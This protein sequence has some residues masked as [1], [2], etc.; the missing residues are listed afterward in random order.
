MVSTG[1][2]TYPRLFFFGITDMI[3]V[4]S[5]VFLI[6]TTRVGLKTR[7]NGVKSVCLGRR[8]ALF[9]QQIKHIIIRVCGLQYD[10]TEQSAVA[11]PAQPS[12][13]AAALLPTRAH[14]RSLKQA[15]RTTATTSSSYRNLT[16]RKSD[17]SLQALVECRAL[18][19]K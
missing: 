13:Q 10:C 1:S 15:P 5:C 7:L 18:E 8:L 16:S 2:K 3:G 4:D 12:T 6:V 9:L 19:P 11:Q 14:T 17:F